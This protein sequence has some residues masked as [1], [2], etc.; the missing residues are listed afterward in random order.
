MDGGQ[1]RVGGFGRATSWQRPDSITGM[2]AP[3]VD[4]DARAWMPRD[5]MAARGMPPMHAPRMM[6]GMP[7]SAAAAAAGGMG[8]AGM[9]EFAAR[10]RGGEFARGPVTALSKRQLPFA[11]VQPSEDMQDKAEAEISKAVGALEGVCLLSLC[12]GCV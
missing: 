3:S 10:G 6:M 5:K 1:A 8:A 2:Q 11:K 12:L 4:S 7:M 9:G